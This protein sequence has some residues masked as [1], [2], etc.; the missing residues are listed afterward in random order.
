VADTY[1]R[2]I[3]LGASRRRKEDA[4][5]LHDNKRWHGAIYLGGYA[6]ECSMKALLCYNKHIDNLRKSELY[7]DGHRGNDLHNLQRLL[8]QVTNL[9]RS[10]RLDRSGQYDPAWKKIVSMWQKDELRYGDKQGNE[11]ESQQFLDAVKIM[12]SLVLGLQ[13][14]QS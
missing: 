2:R 11:Q 4:Q 7:R 12:H 5:S 1:D 8:G 9:E 3:Q 13:K 10:I 6:I 14:E